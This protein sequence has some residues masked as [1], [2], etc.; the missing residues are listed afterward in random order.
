MKSTLVPPTDQQMEFAALFAPRAEAM[1][2]KS[3]RERAEVE[4]PRPQL[5]PEEPDRWDAMFTG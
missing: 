1:T 3:S 2:T 4:N 5:Q